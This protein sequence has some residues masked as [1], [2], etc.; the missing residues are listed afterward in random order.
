[1]LDDVNIISTISGGSITGLWYMTNLC[2]GKDVEESIKELFHLLESSSIISSALNSMMQP[3]NANRSAIKEF[4]RVYDDIFFHEETF[5][6]IQNGVDRTHVHHFSANGTDFS[7]GIAFRFQATEELQSDNPAFKRGFIGNKSHTVPWDVASDFKL[8]EILAVSSCFPGGFEPLIYPDD[9]DIHKMNKH[10]EYIVEASKHKF[11]L[12]D[13]G[14]VDNQG[15]QP[16]QLAE[17]QMSQSKEAQHERI[18][19]LIIVSD[20]ASP[21]IKPMD[22]DLPFCL[23]NITWSGVNNILHILIVVFVLLLWYLRPISLAV[24]A[25]SV[26]LIMT[27]ALRYFTYFAKNAIAKWL[28]KLPFSGEWKLLLRLPFNKVQTMVETRIS[29]LLTLAQGVFMKPIRQMR[30]NQLYEDNSWHNRLIANNVHELSSKGSYRWKQDYP[31]YLK[32]SETMKENSDKAANMDTT[33]WFS[34]ED[35]ANGIPE[36]LFTSGQYTICMNLLE[37]LEKIEK[38]YS[39]TNEAHRYLLS[40]KSQLVNDW[41]QF[42]INPQYLLSKV[43]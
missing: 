35:K 32:P 12:M 9:F 39:N 8:S 19:D 37:Y 6:L 20:V 22:F 15:I 36:A 40:A 17:T 3:D 18:I 24:G 11:L 33:L 29:S 14:I 38:D 1:M 10:K 28:T 27:I 21:R 16:I 5:S 31:D 4:I 34:V 7:T 26:C 42:L 2:K 23:G 41:N 43:A 25:I 30:Y 13:G